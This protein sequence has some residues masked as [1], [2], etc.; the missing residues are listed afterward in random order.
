MWQQ[1]EVHTEM[2]CQDRVEELDRLAQSPDLNPIKH[3]WD[4]LECRLRARPNCPTSVPNLT[5]ALEAEW[6]QVPAT[7]FQ[8]KVESIP[9]RVEAVIAARGDQLN[10]NAHYF[11]MRCST[12]RCPHTFFIHVV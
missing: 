11:G 3:L 5:N 4:E 2:V 1:S 12:N 9:R 10:I 7:I 6:K 8:H